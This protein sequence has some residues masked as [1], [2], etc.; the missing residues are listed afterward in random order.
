MLAERTI[1]HEKLFVENKEAVFFQSVDDC[2]VKCKYY[3][4]N[5]IERKKIADA[6]LRRVLNDN[7][8]Y[9]SRSK[10]FLRIIEKVQKIG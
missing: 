8:D 10:E 9:T 6:G 4:K 1:D 3:L 2:I 7:Y 5:S